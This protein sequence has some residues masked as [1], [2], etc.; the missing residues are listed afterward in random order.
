MK[1]KNIIWD[2]NGTIVDDSWVFVD[3][4]N[5][6]LKKNNLPLISL[7]D[8]RKNFC[9]PIQDYW[10]LLGFQ[11]NQKEFEILNRG[12]IEQYQKKMFL[13]KLHKGIVDIL[14]KNNS[15]NIQQFVLSASEQKLLHQSVKYYNLNSFFS[16]IYGVDNLNA[17]G[18][19]SLGRR[20]FKNFNLKTTET[21]LIGDTP[22]DADVAKQLNCRLIL[23]SCGHINFNTLKQTGNTVVRSIRE[24]RSTIVNGCY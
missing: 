14:K 16:G 9:F 18:K 4:M 5:G 17:L 22:Y 6:L 1:L 19:V 21:L 24:L 13:P 12:F 10:R 7:K 20:L 2:W 15:L 11:F 23:I 3:V 8:Y